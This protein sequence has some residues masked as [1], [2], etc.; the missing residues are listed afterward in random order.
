M[1][2]SRK[3]KDLKRDEQ[4][5]GWSCVLA[6]IGLSIL[7]VGTSCLKANDCVYLESSAGLIIT[8]GIMTISG[9]IPI[10]VSSLTTTHQEY[11]RN[12]LSTI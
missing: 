5:F 2:I 1:Y 9:I 3:P 11:L 10:I 7:I 8:G 6:F 4:F 12:S